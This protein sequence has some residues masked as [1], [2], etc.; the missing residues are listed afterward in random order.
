MVLR[1]VRDSRRSCLAADRH[2]DQEIHPI[3]ERV[4]RIDAQKLGTEPAADRRHAAAECER[5]REQPIDIDAERCRHAAVIDRGAWP[6]AARTN[7]ASSRS[8]VA[9]AQKAQE[10]QE[11]TRT[12]CLPF[13][14]TASTRIAAD[15]K[16]VRL[17]EFA[18]D[19]AARIWR[20]RPS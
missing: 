10:E 7:R 17:N 2:R 18:M 8:A 16:L 3:F 1:V 13:F 5:D 15:Y 11:R 14:G 4:L 9:A 12:E 6:I 20:F 19:R